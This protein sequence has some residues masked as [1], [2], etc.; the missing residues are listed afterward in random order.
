M[1]CNIM[2]TYHIPSSMKHR[3]EVSVHTIVFT[4]PSKVYSR[5]IAEYDQTW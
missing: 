4:P 1:I 2:Q 3:L 5:I